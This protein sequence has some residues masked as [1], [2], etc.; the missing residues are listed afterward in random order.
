MRFVLPQRRAVRE[1]LAVAM[2][3]F[4]ATGV[5]AFA[6]SF[7]TWDAPY[8]VLFVLFG[9]ALLAMG[10]RIDWNR[11]FL[12]LL[13]GFYAL[14]VLQLLW[15]ESFHPKFLL[16]YPISFGVAYVYLRAL[17]VRFFFILEKVI[18]GLTICALVIWLVD[19]GTVGAF[20]SRLSGLN[21]LAPY[22][23]IIDSYVFLYAVVL[24]GV[25]SFIPRNAGFMWEPGAF[26]VINCIALTIS[27]ARND[28]RVVGNRSAQ[29]LLLGVLSSQSTTGYSILMVIFLFKLFS[30]LSGLTR[31]LVIPLALF[32]ASAVFM[33]PF[34]QDKMIELWNQDAGELAASASESWNIDKPVAAQRFLSLKLD[35]DD[36]LENPILGY[37]GRESEMGI[38][39]QNLNIVTISGIGK[40]PAKFGIFGIVFFIFALFKSSRKLAA[41]LGCGSSYMF[42]A[43]LLSVAVSYSLIEHPLVMCFWMYWIADP[44]LPVTHN[45]RLATQ[46]RRTAAP[47]A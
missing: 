17:G 5:S 32:A 1:Y 9:T 39:K 43:V 28:F 19:V 11:R 24:E 22:D 45:V 15:F 40:I 33:L 7:T 20:R 41:D 44:N 6:R 25:D 29:I 46:S 26:A 47:I 42:A 2:L 23:D 12:F 14:F 35:M 37:G 16:L 31:I 10:H 27:M 4:T 34:M 3:L 13:L 38:R 36:F 18:V 8:G 30:K 21:L